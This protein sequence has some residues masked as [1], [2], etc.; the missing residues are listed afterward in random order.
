MNSVNQPQTII[1]AKA[2]HQVPKELWE[3]ALR[4]CPTVSG[5]AIRDTTN[6]KTTLETEHYDQAVTVENMLT[7]EEQA[8]AYERVYY[9]AN[10][11]GTHTKDDVQPF[12]LTIMESE[13]DTIG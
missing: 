9:L 11:P 8:K 13:Q 7:L 3:T 1:H 4:K 10:M 5:Y 2:G 6:G 12:V